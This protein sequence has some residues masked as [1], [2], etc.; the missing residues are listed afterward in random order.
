MSRFAAIDRDHPLRL[1]NDMA[2][3]VCALRK[4]VIFVTH[5]VFRV[6]ISVAR[7]VGDDAT[8][9]THR[10]EIRIDVP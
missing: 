3:A 7:V 4:T 10:R 5:S 8:D 1:N 9:G 2:L 6:G